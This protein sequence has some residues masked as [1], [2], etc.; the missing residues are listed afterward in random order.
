MSTESHSTDIL[1]VLEHQGY[2]STFPRRAIV[3]SLQ[4]R[5][6]GFTADDLVR[7][8]PKIGRATIFRTIKLLLEAGVICKLSLINGEPRY[9]LSQAEHHHHTICVTCGAVG[10]FH[11]ST[12]ERMLRIVGS[13]I[14]GSIVGH[15]IEL[16]INCSECLKDNLTKITPLIS[17]ADNHQH[18]MH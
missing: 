7:E 3:E 5:N 2:R 8:L 9:S 10:E 12:V 13:E 4:N 11:A 16:Y 15:R 6:D 14:A 1:A 17:N 18:G